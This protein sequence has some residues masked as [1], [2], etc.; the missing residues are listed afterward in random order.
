MTSKEDGSIENM[1][2]YLVQVYM[3]SDNSDFIEREQILD[4]IKS[5]AHKDY[6]LRNLIRYDKYNESISEIIH[7]LV[8]T[9]FWLVAAYKDVFGKYYI[10]FNSFWLEIFVY[11]IIPVTIIYGFIIPRFVRYLTRYNI[12]KN[13]LKLLKTIS[14]IIYIIDFIIFVVIL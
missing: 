9:S 11:I 10:N 2:M 1:T 8:L 5:C 13:T 14:W 12:S 3:Y 7:L 6:F 4:K